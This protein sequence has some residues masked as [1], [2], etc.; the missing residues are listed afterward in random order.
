MSEWFRRLADGT[1][2]PVG[3]PPVLTEEAVELVR[4]AFDLPAGKERRRLQER[5]VATLP[6]AVTPST[7]SGEVRDTSR[8]RFGSVLEKN[9]SGKLDPRCVQA[10]YHW[11][12]FCKVCG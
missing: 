7:S 5:A 6:S 9:A 3:T 2:E 11:K 10:Q 4:E 8:I 1:P 12:G